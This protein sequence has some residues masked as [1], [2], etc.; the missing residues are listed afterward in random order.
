MNS[1]PMK[2]RPAESLLCGDQNNDIKP[3]L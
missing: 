2:G 1:G 3:S